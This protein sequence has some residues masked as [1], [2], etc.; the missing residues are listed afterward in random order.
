MASSQ[1]VRFFWVDALRGIAA[2]VIVVF[3][4]HHF[5]LADAFDRS[6]IPSIE[7]FPYAGILLPLYSRIASQAVE[8]FWLISGFVFA[9]VYLPRQVS[10][11]NFFVARFARLYPLHFATLLY[12]MALQ[13]ISFHTVGHWQVYANNDIRHFLLQLSMS[14]NWITWS[15]GLSFNG[16]IWSVSLEIVV[17]GIFFLSLFAIRRSPFIVLLALSIAS[18]AWVVFQP[19]HLPL[20]RTGVFVCAGYF[21][22]GSLLYVLQPNKSLLRLVVLTVISLGAV[23]LGIA[24][25]A[26]RIT[27]AGGALVLLSL[28][29]GLDRVAPAWGTRLSPLGDISYSVYLV[30]VPLQ[31]TALLF[32]D[33]AFNG[34]RSFA[35]SHFTLPIYVII[36]V[37]MA[38]ALHWW[39]ERPVGRAIRSHMLRK[40]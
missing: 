21:F 27:V 1:D 31:M 18:W 26:E 30:H 11:W 28:A 25:D 39:L 29:A 23:V 3:H 36:S 34:S 12:V 9:H 13:T 35:N 20:V 16:P 7:T 8:L 24:V 4:Y 32:A 38:I 10:A 14:S 17:Y 19:V 33:L 22:L 5:Y 40:N 6:A 2:L 37:A 15:R